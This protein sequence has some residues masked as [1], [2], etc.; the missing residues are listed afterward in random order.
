MSSVPTISHSECQGPEGMCRQYLPVIE[1]EKVLKK[2]HY[3][4]HPAR[5][6]YL[7]Y[8][9]NVDRYFRALLVTGLLATHPA[10]AHS[11]DIVPK[12]FGDKEPKG[13]DL[14]SIS[15][16]PVDLVGKIDLTIQ[17]EI[18]LAFGEETPGIGNVGWM[19]VFSDTSL[20][21]VD[22]IADAVHEFTLMGEYVRSFGSQGNGPGEYSAPFNVSIDPNGFVY[23]LESRG[24]IKYD[25]VGNYLNRWTD[26]DNHRVLTG[27]SGELFLLGNSGRALMSV[28]RLDPENWEYF[29]TT[30]VSVEKEVALSSHLR[31]FYNFSYSASRNRIYYIGANDY[32]V[33]EIDPDTGKIVKMFGYQPEGF[34]RLPER[35]HNYISDDTHSFSHR[36]DSVQMFDE[37]FEIT[38]LANMTLFKDKYLFIS[39][40]TTNSEASSTD[41]AIYDLDGVSIIKAYNLL[42]DDREHMESI[43]RTIPW[44]QIAA[45]GDLLHIWQ[46][47]RKEVANTSNGTI[48][49]YT[50]SVFLH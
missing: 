5:S 42:P 12:I 46:P 48:Q 13:V 14:P 36:H 21:I 10:G 33:K 23:L 31:S 29:F 11:W 7:R 1:G 41:W 39:Y 50:V 32:K 15:E 25:R 24:I 49:Q 3:L 37:L 17:G 47:P 45:W 6:P 8:A 16:T 34:V 38:T 18:E 19:G 27:R 30:P 40:R 28:S 26:Y 9:S 2:Q 22:N 43:S 44:N 35:F 20:L 4:H